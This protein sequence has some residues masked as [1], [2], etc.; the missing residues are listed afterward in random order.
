MNE[1]LIQKYSFYI[2]KDDNDKRTCVFYFQDKIKKSYKLI[3]EI[4]SSNILSI[5]KR[6]K[7]ICVSQ[8]TVLVSE[9]ENVPISL[10]EKSVISF[11]Y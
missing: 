9:H 4:N 8:D 7:K 3:I 1:I 2:Q 5:C 10:D 6:I 11:S